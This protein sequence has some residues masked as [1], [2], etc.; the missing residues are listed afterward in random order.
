MKEQIE[1]ITEG[2]TGITHEGI[3][4]GTWWLYNYEKPRC[5]ECGSSKLEAD[6]QVS[7]DSTSVHDPENDGT[8]NMIIYKAHFECK[9]C[10]A[11]W[12]R[13]KKQFSGSW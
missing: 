9:R 6:I 7:S 4:H 11:E 2:K 13:T 12:Y 10:K 3:R 1:T 5:Q 8:K